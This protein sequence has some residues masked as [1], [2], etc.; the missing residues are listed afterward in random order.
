MIALKYESRIVI[1]LPDRVMAFE[2]SKIEPEKAF[3]LANRGRNGRTEFQVR[4]LRHT[5]EIIPGF[6]TGEAT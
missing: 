4:T 5:L 3:I 1:H 2:W 6:V